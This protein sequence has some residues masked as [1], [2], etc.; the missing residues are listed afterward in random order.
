MLDFSRVLRMSSHTCFRK[1]KQV[2]LCGDYSMKD[3]VMVEVK[4]EKKRC[5]VT[6]LDNLE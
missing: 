6:V 2:L 5:R 1:V 3:V 4:L